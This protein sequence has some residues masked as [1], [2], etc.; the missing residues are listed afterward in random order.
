MTALSGSITA[1]KAHLAYE[2]IKSGITSGRF[3]PGYRLVLGAIAAE[4]SISVVPVREA[5]RLL[6]AEGFVTFERNVGA[7]VA[8]IDEAEYVNAMEALAVVEGFATALAA[9]KLGADDIAVARAV[10]DEMRLCLAHFD[11]LRFTELNRRFHALLFDGCPNSEVLDLVR[12]GWSRLSRL[13]SS[14]FTFVP[15]RSHE[16][17]AEHESLLSLIES[18]SEPL[19][20]ELAIRRHRMATLDAF[21]AHRGSRARGDAPAGALLPPPW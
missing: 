4:L 8:L 20:I 5:I 1:S 21:R 14:T 11:P 7:R 16:S 10:N 9:P 13:R 3:A 18:G 2:W 17:V 15:G 12:R 6:E 19:G